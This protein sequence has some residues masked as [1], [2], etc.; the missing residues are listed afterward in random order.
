MISNPDLLAAIAAA[1]RPDPTRSAIHA[2]LAA[3]WC[4]FLVS[5]RSVEA[6]LFVALILIT[7]L[8]FREIVPCWWAAIRTV[9]AAALVSWL[10]LV[11]IVT[12][13]AGTTDSIWDSLPRRQFLVPSLLIPVVH[14][15][16]LLLISLASGSLLTSLLSA[17]ESA[18]VLL[19]DDVS[20]MGWDSRGGFI[21]PLTAVAGLAAIGA[22]RSGVVAVGALFTAI[23]FAAIA[24][25]SQRSSTA[26]AVI[27]AVVLLLLAPWPRVARLGVG[28]AAILVATIAISASLWVGGAASKNLGKDL[29][30]YSSGRLCLWQA[31]LDA[32]RER[33]WFGYGLQAWRAVILYRNA[34]DP[35]TLSCLA[36]VEA[37]ADSVYSHNLEIDLLF[38]SGGIGLAILSIGL[39]VGGRTVL[40][41]RTAEPLTAVAVAMFAATLATGQFDHALARGIPCGL[42]MLFSTI[43]LLPRPDQTDFARRRLGEE[44]QWIDSWTSR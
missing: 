18:E 2:F 27:G 37:N 41:R 4:F 35:D 9:P 3:A 15:W 22:R 17:F 25:S 36:A 8:R 24:L 44:D 10:V 1:E 39:I 5:S 30:S 20:T 43:C 31:T 12:L 19:R 38:E 7:I 28:G 13:A 21:L 23:A 40:R 42:M 33:P 26:A 32:C 34:T 11:T 14:R 16:R 6:A 29:N